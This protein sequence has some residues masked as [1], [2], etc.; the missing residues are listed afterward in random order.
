MNLKR[1]MNI[2]D[3][4]KNRL[5]STYPRPKLA[6]FEDEECMLVNTNME[7]KENESVYAIVDPDTWTIKLP[8][9]MTF[10]YTS[11]KGNEYS[12]K[13]PITK[14]SDED[15]A[16]IILHEIGHLYAGE[17]YGYSSKQYNNEKYCDQFASRWVSI[18]Y[19]EKL[20]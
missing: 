16:L 12:N 17:R 15:I 5:P 18:L 14:I 1:V 10:K 7:Q 9:N 19:N 11:I 2:Y 20:L 3:I 8:L 13:I 4:I 6:F